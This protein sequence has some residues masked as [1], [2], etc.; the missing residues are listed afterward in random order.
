MGAWVLL[1]AVQRL[2]CQQM[3]GCHDSFVFGSPVGGDSSTWRARVMQSLLEQCDKPWIL[4]N[5]SPF[6]SR[7]VTCEATIKT[8]VDDFLFKENPN[9]E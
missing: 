1:P 8:R 3:F 2:S 9:H 7:S 4:L 5:L 6:E